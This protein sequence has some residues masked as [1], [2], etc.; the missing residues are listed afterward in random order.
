M[1]RRSFLQ[2]LALTAAGLVLPE[3]RRA[4]P[5]MRA[6][7][8]VLHSTGVAAWACDFDAGEGLI[9][10]TTGPE[11]VA[12]GARDNRSGSIQ[13]WAKGPISVVNR[14]GSGIVVDRDGTVMAIG[15]VVL[16][17]KS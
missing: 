8:T 2:S 15:N 17:G 11:N 14:D 3:R 6:G 4:M 10:R 9:F 5:V 13:L 1:N 16:G 12:I 7:D